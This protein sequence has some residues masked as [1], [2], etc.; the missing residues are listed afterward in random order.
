MHTVTLKPDI[1]EQLKH[2]TGTGEFGQDTDVIVDRAVRVY[3]ANLRQKKIE[4]ETEAFEQQKN[5]L[6]KYDGEYV[7]I[8]NGQIVDH[9]SDLRTLHLR[10][11]EQFGHKPVLLKQV[12]SKPEHDLT[13]RNPRFEQGS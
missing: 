9:D 2:L 13:F 8:H 5:A 7:A 11:F 12:I 4:A 1:A 6:T 10:I 3:L